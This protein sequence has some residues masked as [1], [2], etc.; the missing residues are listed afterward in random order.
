MS[1]FKDFI[2]KA[3]CLRVVI[4]CGFQYSSKV[5]YE[6]IPQAVLGIDIVC[7]A[8]SGMGK[9]TIFVLVTLYQLNMSDSSGDVD[10]EKERREQRTS[11]YHLSHL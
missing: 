6:Y 3:E 4:D 11:A 1:G 2:L 10:N 5:Q 8:I 7:Q 9:T